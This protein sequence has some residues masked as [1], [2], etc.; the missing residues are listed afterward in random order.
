MSR[1]LIPTRDCEARYLARCLNGKLRIGLAE[2]TVLTSLANAFTTTEM[3]KDGRRLSEGTL[4]E[5][6]KEDETILKTVYR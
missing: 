6:M 5:A 1:L 4:K 2:Q 3:R